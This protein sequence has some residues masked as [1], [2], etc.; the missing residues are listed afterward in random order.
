M[1]SLPID[2]SSLLTPRAR[3][4]S[5]AERWR[6]V[7]RRDAAA[8]GVFLFS[9][10]TTGVY[11][12]PSCAARTP[13]RENIAFHANAA[14]AARAGFRP[15][16]R[17]QPDLP[18][19]SER[20]AAL[21]AEA[22]RTIESA[23]DEPR[24]AELAAKVGVSPYHFHRMFKRIAGVIPKA[25]GAA[26]RQRR[27]RDT[28][29]SASSVTDAIYTAGFNSS[30]RFYEAAA[31]MLGMKPS[32]YR[33]GGEGE[34]LWFGTARCSLGRVLV[35]GTERGVCAI[36]LG[37]NARSLITELKERF[38]KA[39]F[40]RPD[41]QFSRW[42]AEAVRFID[43][44]NGETLRL[45]LNVRGTAFQRRVWEALCAIPAGKTASYRDI[46]AKL[47]NPDAV[48]AVAGAC[49]ANRLAVAIPCHRA[50]GSDG[51]LTGYRWGVERKR[52]LLEREK[53]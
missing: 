6:A 44:A 28:L 5:D 8:D 51:T 19:R 1:H 40:I 38:P 30:G 15:C 27:V 22:A 39:R 13:R 42:I 25:Y 17:C 7:Q 34:A 16:K 2:Q 45:P 24:L 18:P 9:V 32:A 23:E 20:E 11:C 46:A 26:N 53:A 31:G 50:V 14:T 36:L 37:D 48:R 21:V 52:R 4:A 29:A 35:A 47:G 43:R 41:A 10:K 33:K 49:A 12:R 3:F